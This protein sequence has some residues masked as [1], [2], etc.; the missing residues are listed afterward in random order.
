MGESYKEN[1]DVSIIILNYNTWK[2][3]DEC[4]KSVTK[5]TKKVSFEII[6]VDNG[7]EEKFK[8]Q[9]ANRRTKVKIIRN[10]R[11]LGFAGGNN[12]GLKVAKGRYVLLLNS[13]TLFIQD[14]ISKMVAWMDKRSDVGIATPALFNSDMSLQGSGGYFPNLVRVF[15]W[16]TIQDIP[17]VD[18]IIKPFQPMHR[19]SF[20]KGSGFFASTREL[21]WITGAFFLIRRE[22]IDEVGLLDEDY[23]MYVEELDYC[24]RA[25]A[26]GWKVY[27][28]ADWGVIHLGGASATS[29]F[30]VLESYK[31]MKLFYKKHYP[32]WQYPI[33]RLLL[34]IGSLGR[35]LVFGLLEGKEAAKTYAQAYRT[36]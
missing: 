36:A 2:V 25:K 18:L 19:K 9:S 14:S 20:Y 23:F 33:L 30:T 22:V 21:D 15:S 1:M 35:I 27:Y 13:D 8:C 17:G 24:Y 6:L 26:K 5:Y 10:S 31:S 7:S 11:N 34:K 28:V 3:T 29:R 32:K 4:I 16:M 12:C